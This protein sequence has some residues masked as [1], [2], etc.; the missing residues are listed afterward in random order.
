MTYKLGNINYI[1]KSTFTATTYMK[2]ATE[3]KYNNLQATY[4]TNANEDTIEIIVK[5]TSTT[6]DITIT[7]NDNKLEIQL[8]YC[9]STSKEVDYNKKINTPDDAI[10][11][12]KDSEDNVVQKFIKVYAITDNPDVTDRAFN[13]NLYNG[14][15]KLN[16]LNLF[17]GENKY[18]DDYE[19]KTGFYLNKTPIE[20]LSIAVNQVYNSTFTIK[21]NSELQF[22]LQD[23]GNVYDIML[24]I[25]EE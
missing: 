8:G 19:N 1:A 10:K 3:A 9:D 23:T 20:T 16:W 25:V 17:G 5:N 14:T 11:D 12:I 6:E 24:P 13:C 2:G 7:P 21:A 15:T 18:G 4:Y 22:S